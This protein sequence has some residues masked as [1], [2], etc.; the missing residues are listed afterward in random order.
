MGVIQNP[1]SREV[2]TFHRLET[3]KEWLEQGGSLRQRLTEFPLLN[4]EKH[5][6]V[7]LGLRDCQELAIGNL[8]ASFKHK[9]LVP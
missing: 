1:A 3:H 7:D 8:E 4:P 5:P 6:A 9:N 2:F